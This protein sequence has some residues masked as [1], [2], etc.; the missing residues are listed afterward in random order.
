MARLRFWAIILIIW[1]IFLFNIERLNSPINIQSYTYIFVALTAAMTVMLPRL[2]W[3]SYWSLIF[4]SIVLFLMVK[5]FWH[6]HMIWGAALPLTV[7]QVTAIVLTGLISRQINSGLREFEDVITGITFGRI[8]TLPKPFAE[9]QDSIYRELRRAR[10][11]QRPLSVVTL[12]ID[13]VSVHRVLPDMIKTVQQTMMHE[14][15]LANVSRILDENMDDF[16]TITL[17]DND[18]VLVLPEKTSNE[19]AAM[20]Q[21]L[22]ELIQAEM[23]I[24]LQTGLANFPD[25]AITFETLIETALKNVDCFPNGQREQEV[26]MAESKQEVVAHLRIEEEAVK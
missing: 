21:K 20:A 24:K 11:Y 8:G 23:N 7:T 18:F 6:Q 26:V 13:E 19:A 10:R 15:V 5:V 2:R 1:L 16:G 3:L 22:R 14:Y 9:V 12:K 17:R 25:E 4:S